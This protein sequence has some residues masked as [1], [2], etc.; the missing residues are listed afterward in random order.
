[1]IK[2]FRDKG[3]QFKIITSLSALFFIVFGGLIYLNVYQEMADMRD[4]MERNGD[5]LATLTLQAIRS[6]M[7]KGDSEGISE[8]LQDIKKG[9]EELDFFVISSE[10]KVTYSTNRDDEGKDLSELIRNSQLAETIDK[11]IK[12]GVTE[13]K[14]FEETIEGQPFLSMLQPIHNEKSC[15]ECHDEGK[16]VLGVFMSRQSTA[17]AHRLLNSL[18]LK[19]VIFGV[20]GFLLTAFVLFLLIRHFVAAPLRGITATMKDIAQGEG[21]LTVRLD[22]SGKDELAELANWFNI[23]VEKIQ[24]TV[25]TTMELSEQ[26]S[27]SCAEISSGSSDLALRTTEEASSVTQTSATLEEFTQSVIQSSGSVEMV[28]S[29]IGSLNKDL[30]AKKELIDNTTVTMK[31]INESGREINNIANV[32]NDISFQ[33]NLLA[34]NAAVEAARAGDAGRGFA[35][36][37]S[38]VRNLAQKTTE[39]SDSIKQIVTKNVESAESGMALVRQTSELFSSILEVMQDVLNEFQVVSQASREQSMGIEQIHQTMTELDD[40]VNKNAGLS[41]DLSEMAKRMKINAGQLME[42]MRHFKV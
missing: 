11:S 12:E 22:S 30:N 38:E 9:S 2:I 42:Q 34:L 24:E 26:F 21:D 7:A 1:M 37:A 18:I 40:A 39:A 20:M 13:K 14:G 23:F 32:I 17:P 36:V 15:F 41:K 8:T 10:K 5:S 3:L 25:K 35:V 6:P 28:D 16:K 33:T 19:D 4:E 27:N 29:E 31:S